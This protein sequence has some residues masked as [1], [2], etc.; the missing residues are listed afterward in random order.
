MQSKQDQIQSQTVT[1]LTDDDAFIAVSLKW[2]ED[3]KHKQGLIDQTKDIG[4]Q[5]EV[6]ALEAEHIKEFEEFKKLTEMQFQIELDI[7]NTQYKQTLALLDTEKEKNIQC[8][9]LVKEEAAIREKQ[10]LEIN[11]LSDSKAKL[12]QE[13]DASAKLAEEST[14]RLQNAINKIKELDVDKEQL[15]KKLQEANQK[16]V[17][18]DNQL[19]SERK[20]I[21]KLYDENKHS[22]KEIMK[23]QNNVFVWKA[24]AV[25]GIAGIIALYIRQNTLNTT[26]TI[27][28][29]PIDCLQLPQTQNINN[30]SC[31][32]I[33]ENSQGS[34]KSPT[35]NN[36]WTS[37]V[38]T[39]NPDDLAPSMNF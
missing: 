29:T 1:P 8:I 23:F 4:N 27:D 10:T 12:Q 30:N 14:C 35:Q 36:T 21:T 38:K 6:E 37:T 19:V 22:K 2:H 18:L 9:T 3:Y 20:E 26:P 13:Y 5:K 34:T 31:A 15:Q 16:N 7:L 25:L 17:D 33:A 11:T 39:S 24:V 32:T 28:N